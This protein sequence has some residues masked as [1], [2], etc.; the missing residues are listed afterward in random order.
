VRQSRPAIPE[1]R[2]GR[3]HGSYRFNMFVGPGDYELRIAAKAE[4]GYPFATGWSRV[5]HV[6]VS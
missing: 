3:Y 5:V 6:R 1:H 4:T 2:Q